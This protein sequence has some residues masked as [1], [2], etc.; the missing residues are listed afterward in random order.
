[1][2]VSATAKHLTAIAAALGLM[3][4][5]TSTATGRAGGLHFVAGAHRVVQGNEVSMSVS[6]S[7]AGV[8]CSASV[9]YKG[10][11]TQ[12]LPSVSATG[13]RASWKWRIERSTTP[14]PARVTVACGPAGRASR[15]FTVIGAV[16]PPAIRV[17]KSGWSVRPLAAGSSV[18]YGVILANESPARDALDVKVLVNFVMSD[19]RLIGSA[20]TR[21]ADIAAGTQH[22]MGGDLMFP[23]GAP[24]ARLEIVAT[25]GGGGPATRT[26]PG[27][28]AVRVMPSPWEPF[29]AGSVEGELQNDD[30]AL[31]LSRAELSTVVLDAAGN[32][33]GGGHGNAF[34]AVPPATRLFFKINQGLRA[35]PI[36]RAATALVSVVPTYDKPGT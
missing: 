17:V 19:N 7:P 24:I 20:T 16:L 9:R 5:S 1:M 2:N 8:R 35:I 23:G 34:T 30:P 25:T 33:I 4:A 13:G 31:T 18:S 12:N 3:V 14:G 26:F 10:G 6:V 27:L 36:A 22:A 21:V 15:T 11:K 29:W 32:V 28:S